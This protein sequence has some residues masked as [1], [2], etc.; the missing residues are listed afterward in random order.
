MINP[1]EY[2]TMQRERHGNSRYKMVDMIELE[3]KNK[4]L[5]TELMLTRIDNKLS[6]GIE[7]TAFELRFLYEIDEKHFT[8]EKN[9]KDPNCAYSSSMYRDW[10]N[11]IKMRRNAK[12]DMATIFNCSEDEV[13]DESSEEEFIDSENIKVYIGNLTDEDYY[14]SLEAV[15]GDVTCMKEEFDMPFL[16][17]ITGDAMMHSLTSSKNVHFVSVGGNLYAPQLNE[18]YDMQNLKYVGGDVNLCNLIKADGLSS[19]TYIGGDVN[20]DS[21]VDARGLSSLTHTKSFSAPNLKY[22][23]GLNRM[24]VIDGSAKFNSLEYLYDLNNLYLIN[25]SL[26]VLDNYSITDIDIDVTGDIDFSSR[27]R[28][29]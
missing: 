11:I 3:E 26:T 24:K 4:M 27:T 6:K 13:Y 19:L 8:F 17:Y 22:D 18:A 5:A 7:P 2:K 16:R 21:L 20:F 12:A 28:S 10:A 9:I 15:I 14:P 25:G 29:R 1:N 23:E